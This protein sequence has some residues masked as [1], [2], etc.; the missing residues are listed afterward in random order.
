LLENIGSATSSSLGQAVTVR[1]STSTSPV[2][3]V[4]CHLL[5][6]LQDLMVFSLCKLAN[7]SVHNWRI[8]QR[9]ETLGYVT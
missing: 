2:G 9:T 5:L 3:L 6:S 4:N 8:W 7:T 1:L